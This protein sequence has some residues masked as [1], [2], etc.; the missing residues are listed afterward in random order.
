MLHAIKHC[1]YTSLSNSTKMLP[2]FLPFDEPNL[3]NDY[4]FMNSEYN[5]RLR[6]LNQVDVDT[7]LLHNVILH[8]VIIQPTKKPRSVGPHKSKL[9]TMPYKKKS[10]IKT[11]QE[12]KYPII[13]KI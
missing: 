3:C 6:F 13:W 1:H 10:Y 9:K 4:I 12:C 5:N 8:Q 11:T 7:N 2:P